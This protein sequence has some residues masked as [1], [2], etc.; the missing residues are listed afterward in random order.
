VGENKKRMRC[1]SADGPFCDEMMTNLQTDMSVRPDIDV[2]LLGFGSHKP[3]LG[4]YDRVSLRGRPGGDL[5]L[6]PFCPF[7]GA[8]IDGG[9]ESDTV[10]EL[11]VDTCE[12]PT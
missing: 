6:I 7:C 12:V 10:A 11:A 5:Y 3:D 2:G 9:E 8:R 4:F 1:E